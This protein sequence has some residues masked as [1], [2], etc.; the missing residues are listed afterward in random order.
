MKPAVA[1]FVKTPKFSP[2]KTRLA[3]TLGATDTLKFYALACA[4]TAAVVRECPYLTP[5]WAVAE[6]APEARTAWS[7][8]A[9]TW[10]G[11]GGL[12]AR[13]DHVYAELQARH[14]RVL[15]IG[16]DAPQLTSTLLESAVVALEDATRPF[17]LGPAADGGFWLFG[18][19]Q[20]IPQSAW[21]AVCYSQADTTA[22]LRSALGT[23]GS[24]TTLPTLSDADVEA[25][26]PALAESLAAL[27]NPLP[28]QRKLAA[29][30][31]TVLDR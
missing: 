22:Q 2:V 6:A 23:S 20:P 18:G 28:E 25:D 31:Q 30:L 4:A 17:V 24:I 27:S 9:H 26:L 10:Q 29:W 5:Y 16:A 19:R 3:A 11:E 14:G 13:L 1:I 15:L 12:G 21:T 8:F 7:G